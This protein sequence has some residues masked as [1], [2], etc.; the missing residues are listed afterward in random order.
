MS[1]Y[2]T[3]ESVR[4]LLAAKFDIK[5][6][7]E[8][9]IPLPSWNRYPCPIIQ[10]CERKKQIKCVGYVMVFVNTDTVRWL[11]LEICFFRDRQRA[12]INQDGFFTNAKT[13]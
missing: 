1:D 11:N 8:N 5:S 13:F 3:M 7:G 9:S 10:G 2:Y 4:D 6:T 12:F